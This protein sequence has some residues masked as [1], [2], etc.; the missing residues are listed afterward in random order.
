MLPEGPWMGSWRVVKKSGWTWRPR[1]RRVRI[2]SQV[3]RQR[4]EKLERVASW[5]DNEGGR[6]CWALPPVNSPKFMPLL[7][8]SMCI[9]CLFVYGMYSLKS[10]VWVVLAVFYFVRWCSYPLML[11][12]EC[13][14]MHSGPSSILVRS[15][16]PLI[17]A[18]IWNER[19]A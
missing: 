3:L 10:P 2:R 14:D 18:D 16:K 5:G 19:W 11:R 17:S 4:M 8:F 12:I 6:S 15:Q 13:L 9:G 1:A 7:L